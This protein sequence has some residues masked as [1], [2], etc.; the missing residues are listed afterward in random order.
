MAVRWWDNDPDERFWL[1]ATDRTDIGAD[2]H[3]PLA[4]SAGRDNWRYTLFREAAPGDV[5]FHYDGK[6][7][8]IVARSV[9]AGPSQP[10]KTTWAARG[11]YARARKAVAETLAGYS[12][13]LR[14]SEMLV[15]PVTLDAIRAV[16]IGLD[17]AVAGL[18]ERYGQAPLY[19]P[20]ELSARPVRPM[21][22]YAFKLPAAVVGLLGLE[23]LTSRGP[24]TISAD[25]SLVTRSF[26]KWR[27]ALL[28][29]A[30][31]ETKLWRQPAERFVFTN[32]PARSSTQL[33]KRTA[34]GVDPTG[35]AWAVQINEADKP[36]DLGVTAAIATDESGR[37]YLLRQG[38]LNSNRQSLKP[39]LYEE[40]RRL[41]GLAPVRLTNGNTGIPRD[42]YV[43]TALDLENSAIRQN[44]AHFV[45]ACVMV[46][47][48]GRS[49]GNSEDLKR[50]LELSGNDESGGLYKLKARPAIDEKE[51]QR[52]Q[53]EVWQ[54]MRDVTS[55][56]R[57]IGR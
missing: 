54:R 5:V 49:V 44:T 29:G 25:S 56:R 23:S 30:V 57:R 15:T 26:A 10:I 21:Q 39:V 27:D 48:G 31:R 6:A 38:R 51:I 36:G 1:E 20:F 8:A 52:R 19:F 3:A 9:V 2:L 42:W 40:F 13:P 41:S 45:D 16:R 33:G 28:E 47:A 17:V 24:L 11:S 34:L 4:D 22:G 37:P 18:R 50:A 43:V 7:N 55:Q 46:R 14:D 35:K 53:G 12:V 32:Q